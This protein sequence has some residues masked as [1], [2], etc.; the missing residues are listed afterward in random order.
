MTYAK[1]RNRVLSLL[2][3]EYG[4]EANDVDNYQI[5]TAYN[6]QSTP[7]EFVTWFADKYDLDPIRANSFLQWI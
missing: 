2:K 5:E 4:L 7:E 3:S 6:N 1:F